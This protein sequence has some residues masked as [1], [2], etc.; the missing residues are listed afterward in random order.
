MERRR[1]LRTL[2][3]TGP[4]ST[5]GCLGDFG[6]GP[7]N[8]YLDRPER[9]EIRSA[10]LPYPAYSER[11]PSVRL[12]DP[13][14]GREVSTT[15]FDDELVLV[16]FFYTTCTSI[17]PFLISSLREV[18]TA[19]VDGGYGD[20]VVFL[21]ITFDPGRDTAT[22]L[23]SY[24]RGM[25]VDLDAGN[26]HFLR[27]DTPERAT[28]VV[29]E[30]FGVTFERTGPPDDAMYMFNHLG[31]VVFANEKGYVERAYTGDDP[32]GGVILNDVNRVRDARR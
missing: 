24:G 20:E 5:A 3:A 28:A 2:A 23:R 7:S 14:A 11:L 31:L 15:E 8:T 19:A 30:T 6:L 13:L 21:A 25:H 4:L 9:Q 18:Q 27:P 22:R 1:F 29:E 17:C 10:N 32:K 16:T 12:T 26:W